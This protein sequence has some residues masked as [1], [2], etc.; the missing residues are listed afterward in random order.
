MQSRN[1]I[2]VQTV[3]DDLSDIEQSIQSIRLAAHRWG[4]DFYEMCFFRN[5][6]PPLFNILG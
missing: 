1:I 4:L 2:V 5:P 6:N 3:F